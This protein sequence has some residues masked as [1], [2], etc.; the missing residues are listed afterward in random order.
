MKKC[1]IITGTGKPLL[2]H[3]D[4]RGFPMFTVLSIKPYCLVT[5]VT[6]TAKRLRYTDINIREVRL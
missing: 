2:L 3:R 6:E 4:K 1:R 5:K